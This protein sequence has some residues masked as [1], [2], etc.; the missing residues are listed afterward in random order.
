MTERVGTTW[1]KG[2]NRHKEIEKNDE[3]NDN[4]DKIE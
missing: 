4:T 1:F 2:F 3:N